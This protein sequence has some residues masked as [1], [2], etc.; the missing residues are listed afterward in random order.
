MKRFVYLLTLV[1]LMQVAT[2]KNSLA[3]SDKG[4]LTGHVFD[5]SG[6]V[7]QGA[8]IE[9]SPSNA[10]VVSDQQGSYYVNGL[11][12]GTYTITV[13]YVGFA[14]FTRSFEITAGKTTNLD[15]N[16]D[17]SSQKDQVLVTAERASGE[18]EQVNRQR[19]ADNIVQVLTN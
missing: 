19:T 7:L 3:Q 16:M 12:P 2:A 5:S 6:G 17:V 15:V 9:F 14:L 1:A 13:T 8:E 18:A 11:N 10:V 4:G